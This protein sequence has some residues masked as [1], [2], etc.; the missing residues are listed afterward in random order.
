MKKHNLIKV[1]QNRK[2]REEYGF[3]LPEHFEYDFTEETNKR[4]REI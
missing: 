2:N 4:W 3:R 1:Y